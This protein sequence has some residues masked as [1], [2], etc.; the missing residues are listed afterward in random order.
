MIK[1]LT[2]NYPGNNALSM[3]E[4]KKSFHTDLKRIYVTFYK[5]LYYYGLKLSGSEEIT[6]D[7]IQ[8]M[9][10][11]FW[12]NENALSEI[13]SVKAYLLKCYRRRVFLEL[14]RD[15]KKISRDAEPGIKPE[16][17]L[18]VD[19]IES[20]LIHEEDKKAKL[21]KLIKAKDELTIRQKE[22]LYLKFNLGYN[23]E[24]ICE[25]MSIRYQSVRNLFS[26]TIKILHD[27]LTQ[28]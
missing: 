24:M 18:I 4:E 28:D 9:F 10:L 27:K 5:D 1:N 16:N 20:D 7:C 2:T 22:I 26:E 3:A 19:S 6:R 15:N 14:A 8:D 13:N 11:Q 17:E 23:Y 12:M 21:L 25:I